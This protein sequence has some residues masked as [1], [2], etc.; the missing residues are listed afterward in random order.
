[1]AG[2]MSIP[3]HIEIRANLAAAIFPFESQLQGRSIIVAGQ[4]E[5]YN[6]LDQI[7]EPVKD[8]G[9]PQASYMHNVMPTA[10]GYQAIGYQ[11][12]ISSTD[13]AGD[14]DTI[15]NL[16]YTSPTIVHLLFCP[17]SGKNYIFDG[18]VGSWV[19][20]S[21]ISGVSANTQVTVAT[22]NGISYICYAGLGVYTYST[23]TKTITQVTLTAVT[24]GNI[25]GICASYGYLI[26]WDNTNTVY[27]SNVSNPLDFS[28]SLI[29]G[30]GSAG[31]QA[32]NGAVLFCVP[33]SGGLIVYCERNAVG[34]TYSGNINYPF[35]FR[36]VQGSGGV[37]AS[38]DVTYQ[39]NQAT[40]YA[41]TT[42]GIQSLN[43]NS[44][45]DVFPEATEFLE[46][47]IFED[48]NEQTLQF[49]QTYLS[50]PLFTKIAL[51][52]ERYIVL[53]YGVTYNLY[54]HALVYDINLA[55]WGKLK[56][57]HV[58][59]FE[60]QQPNTYGVLTYAQLAQY[61][62][63][64]LYNVTYGNLNGGQINISETADKNIGFSDANGNI[65]ILDFDLSEALASGVLILGRYQYVRNKLLIHQRSDI[66]N[67]IAGSNYA[68]YIIPTLDGKTLQTPVCISTPA[69]VLSQGAETLLLGARVTGKTLSFLFTGAFN[70][71]SIVIDFTLGG[72][73]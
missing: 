48:F 71:I 4:D 51:I 62:Y 45:S 39:S 18:A 1:M 35:V 59:C 9:I 41:W 70:L 25:Q 32:A 63:G 60:F 20:V 6:Y 15:F 73:R 66:E 38:E 12:A 53:S 42:A 5:N 67:I 28:P 23:S 33:I 58:R 44:A 16:Y 65:Y 22:V 11:P 31:V 36:E 69:N 34:A 24:I 55:R 46:K 10:Q 27:W 7:G 19:S 52:S 61:N 57:T 13:T 50:A 3:Q 40:H 30:A 47:L 21:P 49:T 64:T 54:T 14:F 56:F 43:L 68:V 17:A 37:L 26:L 29:T 8:R 2:S 72:D